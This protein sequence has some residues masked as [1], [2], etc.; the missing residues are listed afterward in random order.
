MMFLPLVASEIPEM[1]SLKL[2]L[3]DV[4]LELVSEFT[5]LGF[6]ID[7]YASLS[8]HVKK[9]EKLLLTAASVSGRLMKQLEVTNT[10]SLR[11]YFYSLVSSQ[12]YGLGVAAFSEQQYIRA[13]KIFL[14]EAW[15]LPRSFPLNLA[16]FILGVEDLEMMALRARMRFLQHLLV[17]N[18]TRASLSAMVLDRSELASRRTGWNHDLMAM[19]PFIQEDLESI[20][21][22]SPRAVRTLYTKLARSLAERKRMR[23]QASA[24][25][26]MTTLFPTLAIPRSL[27]E[28]LGQLP[29]ESVRLFILFLG[30]MTRFSYLRPR[31][32]NRKCPFCKVEMH[33]RH[34]FDCEQYAALGDEPVVWSDYVRMF[35][36]QEWQLA[37]SSL[38]RRVLGWNRRTG[39]F[40]DGFRQEIYM[41]FEELQW[42]RED[43]VR[44]AGG[45]VPTNFPWSIAS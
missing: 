29:F 43:R 39:I 33:S 15:L 16:S 7:S 4:E 20:D 30:N 40:R 9:R 2:F 18:R 22:T 35:L 10:R 13:Q 45:Q 24:H 21:L 37:V 23:T 11:S 3:G 42:Q 26:H 32:K 14:Q 1:N 17:G 34:F 41:I 44:R 19:F 36:D 12:L 25:H 27:G 31:A 28:V 5:Y 6:T 8:L 38:V